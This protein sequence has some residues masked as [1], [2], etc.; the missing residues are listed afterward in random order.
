MKLSLKYKL[1]GILTLGLMLSIVGQLLTRYLLEIPALTALE[2]QAD[3][4]NIERVRLTIIDA[5]KSLVLNAIDYAVWDHSYEFIESHRGDPVYEQ[6]VEANLE[7]QSLEALEVDGAVFIAAQGGIKHNFYNERI[8][9]L[10]DPGSEFVPPKIRIGFSANPDGSV[11]DPFINSGIGQSN[12]GPVV[13][14]A[15]HIVTSQQ[16]YPAPRGILIFWRL[17]D[18]SYFDRVS[19]NLQTEMRVVTLSEATEDPLLSSALERLRFEGVEQLPRDEH[20]NLYW[21][22]RDSANNPLFLVEQST[23]ARGF[24]ENVLSSTVI[25]G[26]ASSALI[27]FILVLAFSHIVINRILN[28]KETMLDIIN[29]GD[30]TRRLASADKDEMDTM[31]SQFNELLEQIQEQNQELVEQNQDLAKLSE[32]DALTGIANRRFLDDVLA[33]SWRQCGRLKT[34]MSVLMID[35]D[36]FKA[37]NDRYGHPAGD[38]VLIKIAQTLQQNLY[39]TTDYL[40]RFGG[41]EFCVVLTDT[42][43]ETAHVIAERLRSG[44]EHLRIRSDESKS[45]DVIT[46]SIGVATFMPSAKM[47]ETNMIKAADDALYEAKRQG[48][49]RVFLKDGKAS[50]THIKLRKT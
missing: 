26:F 14:S 18:E 23:E 4:K 50:V 16:P 20:G 3:N 36:Y 40:A 42:N 25:V 30:Y 24:S 12:L 31:F 11:D 13:F 35:V 29:T 48:R 45:E 49:N 8:D 19:K 46:V 41:E 33:R 37:Y 34:T 47:A 28:A 6:Y 1:V 32:Q 9:A 21:T 38:Q 2:F 15:S 27:L 17:L 22:L 10:L 44:I 7:E 39:R 43:S 5:Q